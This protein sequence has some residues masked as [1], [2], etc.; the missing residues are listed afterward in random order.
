LSSD[1]QVIQNFVA[2]GGTVLR[3]RRVKCTSTEQMILNI[4][5]VT[6]GFL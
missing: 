5:G 4:D 3:P 6:V 1:Y 2:L